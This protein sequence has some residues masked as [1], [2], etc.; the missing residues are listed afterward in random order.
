MI[1]G[2]FDAK[3]GSAVELFGKLTG[4][5]VERF[6]EEDGLDRTLKGAVA[7]LIAQEIGS[8]A[9]SAALLKQVLVAVLRRSLHSASTWVERFAMLKAWKNRLTL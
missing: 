3:Y 1:C 8:G 5:I 2:F 4:P 7:E 9:M 6:D